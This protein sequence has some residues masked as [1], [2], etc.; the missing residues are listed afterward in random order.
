MRWQGRAAERGHPGAQAWLAEA[1][2]SGEGVIRDEA[3]ASSWRRKAA[4][5]GDLGALEA[6]TAEALKP[7]AP[8]AD[9]MEVRRLWLKLA[10]AGDAAAQQRYRQLLL[11]RPDWTVSA[12]E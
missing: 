8:E 10:E 2:S 6:L 12:E 4:E 1:L 5:G 7:R 9:Q 11:E 3:A